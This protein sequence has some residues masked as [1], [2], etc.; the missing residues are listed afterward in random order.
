MTATAFEKYMPNDPADAVQRATDFFH[1][2]DDLWSLPLFTAL[3]DN[4]STHAGVWAERCVLRMLPLCHSPHLES[5][6]ND[7]DTLRELRDRK[8]ANE[9]ICSRGEEIWNRHPARDWIQTAIARLYW[10]VAHD[11]YRDRD[12]GGHDAIDFAGAVDLLAKGEEYPELFLSI[13]IE[14]FQF[15]LER[16]QLGVR[17]SEVLGLIGSDHY[18]FR[19]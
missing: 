2:H 9:E 17:P 19:R 13:A 4:S 6:T 15:V 5:L 11:L 10:G 8:A 12:G 1:V 16:R 7:L 18:G 3:S 14:E